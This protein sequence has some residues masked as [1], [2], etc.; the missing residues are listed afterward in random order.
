MLVSLTQLQSP[1]S[2]FPSPHLTGQGGIRTHEAVTPTRVPVVLL[3]PLGHLSTQKGQHLGE[4]LAIGKLNGNRQGEIRTL[5]TGFARMTVFETVAFNHSATCPTLCLTFGKAQTMLPDFARFVSPILQNFIHRLR[6]TT[7]STGK[8]A[9]DL[10]FLT[11]RRAH[12]TPNLRW[13]RHS[14]R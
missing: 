4:M 2:L 1:F 14:R 12:P 7:R 9:N 10:T 5:D 3:K 13:A 6:A 8:T 11:R